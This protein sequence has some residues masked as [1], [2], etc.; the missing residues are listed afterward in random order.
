V[1]LALAVKSTMALT[2]PS[3]TLAS[4]EM[5]QEMVGGVVSPRTVTSN[6]QAAELPEPSRAEHETAVVPGGNMEPEGCEHVTAASPQLSLTGV[7]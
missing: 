1:S 5:G 4:T 7:S 3:R 2:S 6:P